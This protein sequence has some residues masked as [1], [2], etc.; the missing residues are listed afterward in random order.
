L[1]TEQWKLFYKILKRYYEL[2]T[3]RLNRNKIDNILEQEFKDNKY[4]VPRKNQLV[5]KVKNG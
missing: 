2:K 1:K 4:F 5:L 3:L